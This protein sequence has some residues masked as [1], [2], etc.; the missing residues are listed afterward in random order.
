MGGGM[1][2]D[3]NPW[4]M[5]SKVC[6]GSSGSETGV[7][8]AQQT[9]VAPAASGQNSMGASTD[10]NAVATS[11]A[12]TQKKRRQ[13]ATPVTSAGGPAIP[14]GANGASGAAPIATGGS[15]P[16]SQGQGQ[17]Q[18]RGQELYVLPFPP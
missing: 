14:T 15:S 5:W 13:V 8:G 18:G 6:S 4:E 11:A 2:G 17:G 1:G 16:G 3:F 12:V 7:G 10:P 9:A